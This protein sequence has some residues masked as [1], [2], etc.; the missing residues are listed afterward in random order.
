MNEIFNHINWLHVLV[1]AIAYFILGAVWYSPVLFAKKWQGYVNMD[2]TAPNAKKGMGQLMI[3]SFILMLICASGI[4]I[5]ANKMDLHGVIS[6]LKLGFLTGLCFSA[7]AIHIAYLYE[8]K[9]L[10][11]HLINA[12]Y[13]V[14]GNIIAAI[15]ICCWR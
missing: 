5:L 6:G 9:P 4:D 3:L 2:M 13:S 1:A 11:L 15:I 7:S 10:G 12:L 8:K 14:A